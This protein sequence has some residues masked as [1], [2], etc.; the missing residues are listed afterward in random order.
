LGETETEA[1][2]ETETEREGG[3]G[4]KIILS[5]SKSVTKNQKIKYYLKNILFNNLEFDTAI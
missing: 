1:E 2:R 3:T 4:M 5:Y